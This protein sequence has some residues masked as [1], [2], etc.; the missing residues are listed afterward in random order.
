[1]NKH[2]HSGHTQ[3]H[4]CGCGRNHHEH[5]RE[6]P[7]EHNCDCSLNYHEHA[8]EHLHEHN[9]N[10]GHT[11][12]K[13][14]HGHSQQQEHSVKYSHHTEKT[15][16]YMLENLGCAHCAAK[17]EEQIRQ[18]EGISN[19]SIT[20]ATRQLRVTAVEPDQY[21]SQI[22]S[23][24]SRIESQV[25]VVKQ[26]P[27]TV[28]SALAK[29]AQT[30]SEEE[31]HEDTKELCL[32]GIGALLFVIGVI[33]HYKQIQ[34]FSSAAIFVIGYLLLGGEILLEAGKNILKGQIFDENFLMSIATLGAFAIQEYPEAMGIMLFYRIGE[35]LNIKLWKKAAVRLWKLWICDLKLSI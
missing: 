13:Y 1:M 33:L 21:L 23:I 22:R 9:C 19:A 26:T 6:H 2:P 18:I 4:H 24:C 15:C 32:I 8:Q 17:M 14:P 5:V 27:K 35:F 3:E 28:S 25:S 20:Y 10:C 11:H 34:G 31:H 7:H 12:H 16:I 30:F 29:T